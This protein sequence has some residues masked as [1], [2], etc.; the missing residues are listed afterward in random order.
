MPHLVTRC[1]ESLILLALPL[2]GKKKSENHPAL[3]HS[4][5]PKQTMTNSVSQPPWSWGEWMPKRGDPPV[6]TYQWMPGLI[7]QFLWVWLAKNDSSKPDKIIRLFIKLKNWGKDLR[8]LSRHRDPWEA[9]L[10]WLTH[11]PILISQN[12]DPGSSTNL[13]SFSITFY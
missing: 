2:P 7:K 12:P 5:L 3:F 10:I 11:L 6:L 1:M 4:N 8:T 9:W 13:S